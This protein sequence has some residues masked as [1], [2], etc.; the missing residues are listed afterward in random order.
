VRESEDHYPWVHKTP[1]GYE[2]SIQWVTGS[3]GL[4][5]S[6]VQV[7]P[8]KYLLKIVA[9]VNLETGADNFSFGADFAFADGNLIKLVTLPVHPLGRDAQEYAWSIEVETAKMVDLRVY[10][11]S[12]WGTEGG[13]IV[14][15]GIRLETLPETWTGISTKV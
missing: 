10:I 7:H 12:R 15:K 5:Q 8:G 14:I 9:D 4:A 1:E 13:K 11:S 6:G 2:F 3:F